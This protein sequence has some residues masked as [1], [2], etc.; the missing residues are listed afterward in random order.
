MERDRMGVACCVALW[1]WIREAIIEIEGLSGRNPLVENAGTLEKDA[2]LKERILVVDDDVMFRGILRNFVESLGYFCA[3]ASSG[4]TGSHAL[5]KTD[6]S[7][8]ISDIVMPEMDGLELLHIINSKYSHVD[9]LIISGY[10]N[11]YS[12]MEII[13]A[14]ASDFLPKPFTMEQLKAR[15]YKI[16]KEKALKSRLYTKAI[17]DEMTGLYNRGFFYEKLRQEFER[18]K[19]QAHP[20]SIVLL[21]VNGF[22]Q[23]NDRYGHLKGDALL[24]IVARVLRLS[25]RENV[26][27]AFRYGGD[28]FVIILPET[29]EETATSIGNRIKDNFKYA[30]PDGL[31][32]SM[33]VAGL[34]AHFDR[35]MFV[36]KADQKMYEDKRKSKRSGTPYLAMDFGADKHFL[37]CLT[38]GSLVYWASSLCEKCLADPIRKKSSGQGL[39]RA[40][41]FPRKKPNKPMDRRKK[42]R[43]MVRKTFMY[44]GLVAK[45]LNISRGGA[46]IKTKTPLSVGE[47]LNMAFTLED[48]IVRTCGIVVYVRPVADGY[49][50]AGIEFVDVSDEGSRRFDRFFDYSQPK[51][52]NDS[53]FRRHPPV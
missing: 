8:V 51:I 32:L 41:G 31:T 4:Q 23:I 17:T 24:K 34:D 5:E 15:L 43:V 33:G 40:I 19:R 21:D 46:Q 13:Q 18:T 12:P 3:E 37:R 6:F 7:I 45:I 36:H 30:A 20:L 35:Q 10:E 25:I 1:P 22:K 2:V 47:G 14:G 52:C 11:R 29:D 39:E 26:D 53:P 9:V 28:E 42:R 27:D 49:F 48:G 16:K 44:D 50:L 38:C